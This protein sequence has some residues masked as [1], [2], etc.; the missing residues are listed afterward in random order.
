MTNTTASSFRSL[1]GMVESKPREFQSDRGIDEV[2]SASPSSHMCYGT[3]SCTRPRAV[4]ILHKNTR[5]EY[6]R[7]TGAT[8]P[9]LA[10]RRTRVSR[11]HELN[12][13]S[14]RKLRSTIREKKT[15]NKTAGKQS[16]HNERT[17]RIMSSSSSSHS[18]HSRVQSG[19]PEAD[20]LEHLVGA[21]SLLLAGF[22]PRLERK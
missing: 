13:V 4:R 14:W 6:D 20:V 10:L 22:T 1:D 11:Q 21:L 18:C 7:R 9:L 5:I 15:A 12:A 8:Q 3:L 19:R 17:S 16:F 2:C